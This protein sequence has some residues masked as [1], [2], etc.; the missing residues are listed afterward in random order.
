[1]NRVKQDDLICDGLSRKQVEHLLNLLVMLGHDCATVENSKVIDESRRF[2]L[3]Y[4]AHADE[5]VQEWKRAG[6][7]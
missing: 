1:M 3:R 4:P 7:V 5:Y 2:S 6:A